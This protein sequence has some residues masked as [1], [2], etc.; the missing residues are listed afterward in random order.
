MEY[1]IFA[2]GKRL[3]PLLAI[4]AAEALGRDYHSVIEPACALELIHTYSLIHDDLPIMDDD[5]YRRGKPTNHKK[6]GETVAI[7]AGIGLLVRAHQLLI[8]W[9]GSRTGSGKQMFR[10]FRTLTEAS[11]ISGMVGGQV[12]DL[13]SEGKSLT[14]DQIRTIHRLK[15]G[16]M[17]EA[18]VLM[19]AIAASADSKDMSALSEYGRSIGIAFQIVDDILDIEGDL[20]SLGKMPGSDIARVKSTYPSIVGMKTARKMVFEELAKA[21]HVLRSF[22]GDGKYLVELADFIG[23]RKK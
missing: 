19:G 20:E 15:T 17:I 5:D 23:N 22:S 7:L 4:L 3:R 14:I 13:E 1:S 2:G 11:G 6:F 21:K 10:F 18:S 8:V 12:L 9:A 16:A